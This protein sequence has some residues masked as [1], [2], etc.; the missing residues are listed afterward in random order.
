MREFRDVIPRGLVVSCQAPPGDPLHGSAFMARM[1]VAAGLGGA[2]AVR[3]D[4]AADI[5]AIRGA[6]D[7]PIIGICKRRYPRSAVSITATFA[8][9]REVALAGGAVVALDGT[10]RRR[11]GDLALG[12][13]I[14]RIHLELALPVLADVATLEE[15]REA[16]DLGADAVA[17]T[18]SGYTEGAPEVGG[19]DLDLVRRLAGAVGVPVLAEGRFQTPAE[20]EMAIEAGAHAVVVGTAITRPHLIAASFASALRRRIAAL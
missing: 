13:L 7:L 12:A 11:P 4:G 6:V 20:A 5:G 10:A 16:A 18:L 2:I 1:A 19:P 9:A 14:E 8:E 3:A 15:G 17:S